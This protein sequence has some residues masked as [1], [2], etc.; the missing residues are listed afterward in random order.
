MHSN[1][2]ITFDLDKIRESLPGSRVVA[3]SSLCGLTGTKD[4]PIADF[5]VLVDGQKRFSMIEARQQDRARSVRVNLADHDRFLTIVVTDSGNKPGAGG[6]DW[7][8]FAKSVL[9]LAPAGG[10]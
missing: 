4:Y 6:A 3:F 5:W 7:G 8:I 2:G 9:M 1:S 10:K